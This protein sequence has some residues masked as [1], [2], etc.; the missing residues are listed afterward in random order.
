MF[1]KKISP[2]QKTKRNWI[3]E[4]AKLHQS[5]GKKIKE[6]NG[7][8]IRHGS[9]VLPKIAESLNR[10]LMKNVSCTK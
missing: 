2:R 9:N 8:R 7:L 5:L 4:S 6:E 1:F 3:L 10:L